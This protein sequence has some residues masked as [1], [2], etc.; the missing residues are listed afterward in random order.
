M[1]A[2]MADIVEDPS[3]YA[4]VFHLSCN[5]IGHEGH[6]LAVHFVMFIP[7]LQAQADDEQKEKWLMPALSLQLIGTYAQTELGH[8]TNLRALET[9]AT[10]D[11]ATD[12][13][14]I[15]TPTV[16]A[17]KWWP[18]NLGKSSNHAIVSANLIID[19]KAYGHHNFMVQI[20]DENTH[21]PL[22]GNSYRPM[23]VANSEIELQELPSEISVRKWPTMLLTTDFWDSIIIEFLE[24]IC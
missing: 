11:K 16:T 9:T 1:F 18:G 21:K 22:K 24:G 3:D 13:F 6:P 5:A 14:V 20:R 17:L 23:I 19:G 2:H 10:L 15:H 4:E 8:G 12:E 7:A